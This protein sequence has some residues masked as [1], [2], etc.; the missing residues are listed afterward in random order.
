MGKLRSLLGALSP[1]AWLRAIASLWGGVTAIVVFLGVLGLVACIAAATMYLL[2]PE[3]RIYVQTLLA[4]GLLLILIF[5]V[6]AFNQL[7]NA[8]MGRRGRYG[9][10]TTVMVVAFIAIAALVNFLGDRNFHRFDVTAAGQYSLAPQTVKVLRELTEPVHAV[11]FFTPADPYSENAANL[12]TEYTYRTDKFTFEIIDPEANPAA[13]RNYAVKSYGVVV[14]ESGG[15]RQQVSGSGEQDYTGALLKVTG[16]QQKKVYVLTGHDERNFDD[17]GG[18]GFSLALK[19]LQ[20]DNYQAAPLSLATTPTVPEDAAVLI[21]AGP[22][23]LL[24]ENEVKPIEDYLKNKG[25]VIFLLDPNPPEDIVKLLAPWGLIVEKGTVIDQQSYVYPDTATPAAQRPQYQYAQITKE[26]DTTFFAGATAISL[27][28]DLGKQLD[29][30][31]VV[32]VTAIPLAVTTANSWLARD[33]DPKK[34]QKFSDATD[35]KGPLALAVMVEATAPLADRPTQEA[36][37]AKEKKTR[38]VVIGDSDF[39]SNQY[40][41]SL[42]NSDLFLNS[43]NWLAEEEEL[44]SIRPKPPAFRRMV[45]TQAGWRWIVYSSIALLPLA[46]VAAGAINWYRRR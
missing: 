18:A 38:L 40:F 43:V 1:T 37:G 41:Y 12:L 36:E 8:L 28:P 31:K 6:G 21:I 3:L 11:G 20:A 39:A 16:K 46:V 2:L 35:K 29:K 33:Y 10:N 44:I 26:L 7:K 42:G 17:S 14:F 13:A 23:K 45:V 24:L 19:G 34:E 25:K 22:K 5:I 27:D 4:L 30:K 32:T 15:R 9:T